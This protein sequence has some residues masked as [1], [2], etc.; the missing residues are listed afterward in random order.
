[1][2]SNEIVL[3]NNSKTPNAKQLILPTKQKTSFNKTIDHLKSPKT[4]EI[5]RA[6]P[7]FIKSTKNKTK[8]ATS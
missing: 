6:S 8:A 4:I 3:I 7:D 2:Y 1:M 5:D